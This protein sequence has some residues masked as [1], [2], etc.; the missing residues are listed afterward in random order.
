MES[1]LAFP[2]AEMTMFRQ[3]CGVKL[4]DEVAC[5]ELRETGE[6]ERIL[7]LYCNVMGC[8]GTGETG[9]DERILWL[10]CN[11]MGCNGTVMC[12]GRMTGSGLR[13]AWVKW[14]KVLGREGTWKEVVERYD[15]FDGK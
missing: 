12:C 3:M 13:N 10:Y 14:L 2:R 4:S 7:W 8:N 5:V 1:E 11:G 6:Y 15:K 9:E